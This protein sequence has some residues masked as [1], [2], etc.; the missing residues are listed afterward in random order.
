M[1]AVLDKPIA[2]DETMF[3]NARPCDSKS[4]DATVRPWKILGRCP[5]PAEW[6]YVMKCCGGIALA[7]DPCHDGHMQPSSPNRARHCIHCEAP[8]TTLGDATTS[9]HRI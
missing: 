2:L 4:V 1:T 9:V 8:F 7:C 5:R 6:K 3:E